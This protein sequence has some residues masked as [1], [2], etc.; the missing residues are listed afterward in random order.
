MATV[1]DSLIVELGLDPKNFNKGQKEAASAFL[2]TKDAAVKTGKEIE[3]SSK[4]VADSIS[5][6]TREVIAL[7]GAIAGARSL[8]DLIGKLTTAN[9]ELGRFSANLAQSPQT[10]AAWGAAAQRFGGD[11]KATAD[12]IQRMAKGLYDLR[13]QGKALPQAFYQL[14]AATGR[15]ISTDKGPIAFLEQ[16]AA[17]LKELAARDP[18]RAFNIAQELGV[19]T[20]TF[21]LMKEQG[22]AIADYVAQIEKSTSPSE[23][24]I[25]AAQGLQR[26]WVELSQQ[27]GALI[28]RLYELA[29]PPITKLIEQMTAWLE[30]NKE[31][32]AAGIADAVKSVVDWLGKIDWSSFQSG[33]GGVVS[34]AASA[35]GSI[36]DIAAAI[37]SVIEQI[38]ILRGVRSQAENDEVTLRGRGTNLLPGGSGPSVRGRW[39][40][41]GRDPNLINQDVLDEFTFGPFKDSRGGPLSRSGRRPKG[42]AGGSTGTGFM[43]WLIGPAYGGELNSFDKMLAGMDKLGGTTVDGRPVSRSNPMPVTLSDQGSGSGAFWSNLW[44]S[45]TGAFSGAGGADGVGNSTGGGGRTRS[46]GGAGSSSGGGADDRGGPVSVP[47][48]AGM[49]A[50]ERNKLGLILKYESKGRNVMNYEGRARKLD[51]S[52]AKGFT[53]QGYYQMLNSNWRRLA[54]KLGIK[55][56]NAMAGT[57]EEQTKVALAL[58]RESGIGNWANFNP[59]LKRALLRGERAG[60]WAEKVPDMP[61][62]AAKPQIDLGARTSAAMSS[63]MND[64]RSSS[65][66]SSYDT[67]IGTLNVHTKAADPQGIADVIWGEIDNSIRRSGTAATANYGPA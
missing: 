63:V 39:R 67:R 32:L 3:D 21:N 23:K 64:N 54:P 10:I 16:T 28:S 27:A 20:G 17:A 53:A 33:L 34:E 35:A 2:K 65:N 57:L 30:K 25:K 4:R 55:V 48:I 31:W 41:P 42:N 11:A 49:T 36:K 52:T 24:A 19:D 61:S 59:S 56:R 47:N 13:F 60:K 18:S 44:N 14:E 8:S 40:K 43:D 1:I 66:S 15:L 6:M 22:A 26:A 51:P 37:A 7:F 5:K 12:T 50:D 45:I 9:A 58:L 29:G 62:T 38:N 46:G